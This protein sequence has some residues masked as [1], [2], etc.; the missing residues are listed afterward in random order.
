MTNLTEKTAAEV[1]YRLT[2]ALCAKEPVEALSNIFTKL[3]DP[4]LDEMVLYHYI[5]SDIIQNIHCIN[6]G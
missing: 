2:R 4:D 1:K 6:S 3:Q 5:V